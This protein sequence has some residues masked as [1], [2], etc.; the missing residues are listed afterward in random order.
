MDGDGVVDGLGIAASH[1]QRDRNAACAT[2]LQYAP[3][4]CFQPG[5]AQVEAPQAVAGIGVGAGEVDDQIGLAARQ[6]FFQPGVECGEIGIIAGAIRQFD[7]EVAAFF[8]EGKIAG[9]VD[10][11]GED[12][13]VAVEDGS[14][15]VA[16]MDV[17]VDDGTR[18]TRP[19]ACMARA[20]TAASL[21]TQKPSPRSLWAWCV[22][23]ARLAAQPCARAVRQAAR[24]APA[25]RSER[26]TMPGLHGKPMRLSS[27]ALSSPLL[28]RW[29]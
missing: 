16:L 23:P 17:A 6:R 11:E 9:A 20:A 2:G 22:P 19:S 21:K 3:V 28:T 12:A 15:A 5:K 14:G 1:G 29:T 24:V 27:A 7:I 26:S 8:L 13:V 18:R 25:E 10:R 4:A